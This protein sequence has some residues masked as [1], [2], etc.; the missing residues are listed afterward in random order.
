V[1][2]SE[3]EIFNRVEYVM[4]NIK[5]F[6]LIELMI[7]VAIV[8]ILGA[9][10]YPSYLDHVNSSRRAEAMAALVIIASSQER[11]YT[12]RSTYASSVTLNSGLGLPGFSE[13]GLYTLSVNANAATTYTLT[14]TPNPANIWTDPQCNVFTLT[15]VGVKGVNG[16][17]D[18][19]GDNGD[20]DDVDGCW[21]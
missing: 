11:F 20:A 21:G 10:A 6:S 15:N 5:G 14:A 17:F 9:I 7:S 3:N 19:D 4:T 16:D 1:N 13:T 12:I 8:G 2:S 18:D